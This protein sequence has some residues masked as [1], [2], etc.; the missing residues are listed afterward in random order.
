MFFSVPE[1]VAAK[2]VLPDSFFNLSHEEL[3]REAEMKRKKLE[4]SKLL[5]PKSFREKQAKAARKKYT[6]SII[7]IQFPDGVLLQGVFL[8]SEPTS[9]LYEV[10]TL[11]L[12]FVI[13]MV[14]LLN[15]NWG[16]FSKELMLD[17]KVKLH[18]FPEY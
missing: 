10:C 4:E 8:P 7:R 16:F 5:I 11:P 6:K 3:R 1:S 17:S 15:S 18:L 13:F 2:I 14:E 9:A 12:I